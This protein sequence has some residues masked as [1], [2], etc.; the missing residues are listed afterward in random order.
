MIEHAYLIPLIPLAA[1]LIIMFGAKEDPHSPLPWVGIGAMA[2]CLGIAVSI[3]V[4]FA[5]GSVALPYEKNWEWFSFATTIAG[6][7][8]AYAMPVGVL[9]DPPTS[10]VLVVVTLVSL[11]V[12]IYSVSYL[13]DDKRYK[14]YFSFV[15]FFTVARESGRIDFLW[16]G[17]QDFRVA[18]QVTIAVT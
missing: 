8:F 9:I 16:T 14:R 15:S 12:Q 13:H 17:D 10:V 1:S 11:M 18:E 7:S 6:N 3:F 4:G 2:I 5:A